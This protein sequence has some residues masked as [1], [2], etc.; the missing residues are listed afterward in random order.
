MID[1]VFVSKLDDLRPG[2]RHLIKVGVRNIAVWN[3]R[4]QIFAMDNACYHHGGP[5]LSGD[6][7]DLDGHPCIVCPW[8]SYRIAL[9]TGEG[10]YWGVVPTAGAPAQVLKS[11]GRKQRTHKVTIRDGSVYCSVDLAGP[12]LES[13]VYATMA[14]ANS[15]LPTSKPVSGGTGPTGLH[16]NVRSGHVFTGGSVPLRNLN[17]SPCAVRCIRV[18][19]LTSI[20]SR[21]VFEKERGNFAKRMLAGQWV[22]LQIPGV[23]QRT[24]TLTSVREEGGWF[25]ICVKNTGN[26]GRGGS[27]ALHEQGTEFRAVLV[28]VGGSFSLSLQRPL[29]EA[30]EKRVLM[31]SAGIGI[32]PMLASLREESISASEMQVMHLHC[33][34]KLG[35]VVDVHSLQQLALHRPNRYKL[36]LFLSG[37][38]VEGDIASESVVPRRFA[39]ADLQEVLGSQTAPLV[40]L[41]GPQEFMLTVGEELRRRGIPPEL[42]L[43]E[44]FS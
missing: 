30:A 3:H 20:V 37:H 42:I 28:D 7:E 6:I 38:T 8:H 5:L 19:S 1:E 2:T 23:G 4:G 26:S 14:L 41:C 9:D 39:P 18:D 33:D 15:E 44:D 11:K 27:R 40:M 10:M 29:V 31:I 24:W 25:S 21:F 13:D 22:T 16:S 36:K 43:T 34:R 12:K 35:D 17:D 32:T